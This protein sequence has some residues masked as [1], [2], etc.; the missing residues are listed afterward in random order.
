MRV[1]AEAEL[2]LTLHLDL[3][4]DRAHR[5]AP[6]GK[7]DAG[8]LSHEAAASITA[9]DVTRTQRVAVG[10]V[11][12]DTIVVLRQARHLAPIPGHHADL[13]RPRTQDALGVFLRQRQAIGMTRGEVAE[14]ELDA[15]EGGRLHRL[16]LVEKA[17]GDPTLIQHLDRA[18]V[19]PARPRTGTLDLRA[20]SPLQ[21]DCLDPGECE[22]GRQHH[23]GRPTSDDHDGSLVIHE[24]EWK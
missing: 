14:V 10:K 8:E 2:G 15:R 11:N 13:A 9:D 20:R 24:G 3:G 16:S 5:R 23:P 19:Q 6:S 22:L 12:V 17:L 7:V 18:C 1:V 4:D 21:H